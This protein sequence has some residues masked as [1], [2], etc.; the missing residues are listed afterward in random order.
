MESLICSVY[1]S[2]AAR[3]IVCA[4]PSLR[5]T[6]MLLG[7]QATNK[8][9]NSNEVSIVIK[10]QCCSNGS[11][12]KDFVR[13]CFVLFIKLFVFNIYVLHGA[14]SRKLPAQ[15]LIVQICTS[16]FLSLTHPLHFFK[17]SPCL[18]DQTT[19]RTE[20]CISQHQY[21]GSNVAMVPRTIG[22]YGRLHTVFNTLAWHLTF[23][24]RWDPIPQALSGH[25]ATAT[26]PL[27]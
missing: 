20:K 1:L 17:T 9:T 25:V 4:D 14:I 13:F 8:Q 6:R 18:R 7:R 5:Y 11:P 16:V 19:Q 12:D 21:D 15:K 2:V 24:L 23:C 27:L 10:L 22:V 26:C 3:K